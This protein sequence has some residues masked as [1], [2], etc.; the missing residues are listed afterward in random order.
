MVECSMK[1]RNSEV[2]FSADLT[3]LF[4]EGFFSLGDTNSVIK[5]IHEHA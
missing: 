4:H 5:L 1:N 2:N 3:E